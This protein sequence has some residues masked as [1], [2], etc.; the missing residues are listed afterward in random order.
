MIK[1]TLSLLQLR[2]LQSIRVIKTVGF[3][4]AIV[5][6]FVSI[7]IVFPLLKTVMAF[8]ARYSV[9][10]CFLVLAVIDYLRKDKLFLKTIFPTHTAI[11]LYVAMEYFI[12]MLPLASFQAILGH[13]SYVCSFVGLIIFT[14]LVSPL[15]YVDA[16][17]ARKR[18]LKYLPLKYFELKFFVEASLPVWITFWLVGLLSFIHPGVFIAW[19]LLLLMTLPEI[20][21]WYEGREMLHWK[22]SFVLSKTLSY[23]GLFLCIVLLQTIAAWVFHPDAFYI[24]L[25]GL[26]C[27]MVAIFLNISIKYSGYSP[28]LP[29]GNSQNI[30]S[31]LTMLMLLPGSALVALMFALWKYFNAESNLKNIYD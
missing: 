19:L 6:L 7:G 15:Y 14:A 8:P 3:G 9:I 28:S 1:K 22:R 16:G 25:Y 5:F 21:K 4:L 18:T 31:I 10:F 11:S 30:S 20:F 23:M 26:F 24:F 17:T 12:L 27:L 2:V 13:F 29:A